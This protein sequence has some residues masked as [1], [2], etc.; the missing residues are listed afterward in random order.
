[1]L[2]PLG[3]RP[4]VFVP[5]ELHV[6]VSSPLPSPSP[7]APE[8][9]AIDRLARKRLRRHFWLN[10]L[11]YWPELAMVAGLVTVISGLFFLDSFL[12]CFLSAVV[13][14]G[15]GF[16]VRSWRSL[17]VATQLEF[18]HIAET[19]YKAIQTLALARFELTPADLRDPEPCKFRSATKRDIGNAYAGQRTGSDEKVRRSPMEFLVI[20]F[21][22][23]HLFFFRCVWDLTTGTTIWEE[24][25]EFAY[26]DISSVQ[27]SH[28]KD[29]I[30]IN[31]RT[32][33]L[34]PALKKEGITPLHKHVQLPS[35]ESVAL[36]LI[37]GEQVE[38]FAWKRSAG[39][40]FSGEGK[41]H[42]V[43]AQRLQKLVRELKQ[44][45]PAQAHVATLPGAHAGTPDAQP[46]PKPAP[47]TIRHLRG[48][49]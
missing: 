8:V 26:R 12:N 13:L 42:F 3:L 39:G 47:A 23:A 37:S 33:E 5:R 20:N 1:M 29:T 31:L 49:S 35:D 40:I 24:T 41:R 17:Y 28:K 38:L 16:L 36:R 11:L 6:S 30:R 48:E 44:T 18:D 7:S 27:L 32:R 15:T 9:A 43:T 22:H 34:L 14:A 19:D 4:H 2:A 10:Y 45:R 25:L 21:G 46:T